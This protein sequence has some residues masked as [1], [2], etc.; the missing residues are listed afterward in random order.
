MDHVDQEV[1]VVGEILDVDSFLAV[2]TTDGAAEVEASMGVGRERGEVSLAEPHLGAGPTHPCRRCVPGHDLEHADVGLAG[3]VGLGDD[4]DETV[5]GIGGLVVQRAIDGDG[6][7]DMVEEPRVMA[8]EVLGA[9]QPDFLGAGQEHEDGRARRV[10]GPA[11]Q[12]EVA[13]R[14]EDDDDAGSVVAP[15]RGDGCA[16]GFELMEE[17][18]GGWFKPEVLGGGHDE[19]VEVG[20]EEEGRVI[21]LASDAFKPHGEVDRRVGKAIDNGDRARA[22][23]EEATLAFVTDGLLVAA[24]ALD[25]DKGMEGIGEVNA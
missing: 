9:E 18:A 22:E 17:V 11:M 10:V 6:Q 20:I 23:G 25:G 15:E 8:G 13:E 19:G 5:G 4:R 7:A 12:A 16:I 3:G 2:P 24:A 14:L 1:H 21:G